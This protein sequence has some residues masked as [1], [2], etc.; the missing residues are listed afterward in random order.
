[1]KVSRDTVEEFR[2]FF[3]DNADDITELINHARD[4]LGE[5]FGEDVDGVTEDD[6]RREFSETLQ[7]IDLALNL[8]A[9]YKIGVELEVRNDYAGFVVDEL[10]GRRIA[11]SIAESDPERTL[12]E[13][14]FHYIDVHTGE[15]LEEGTAG[16]DDVVAG[17]AAGI[18]TRLPGWRWQEEGY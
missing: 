15:V 11:G 16:Y 9:L 8:A 2:V 10:I 13:A 12:A 4:R 7:D 3:D 18:Q 5:V 17:V 1:M 6:V 14:T